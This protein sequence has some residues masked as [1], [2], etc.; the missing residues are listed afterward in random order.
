MPFGDAVRCFLLRDTTY[1]LVIK[2]FD[3][4]GVSLEIYRF[5]I[6]CFASTA[7]RLSAAEPT[8]LGWSKA[9]GRK[10]TT[11]IRDS[12]QLLRSLFC[13]FCLVLAAILILCCGDVHPHPGP[14]T[15]RQNYFNHSEST[16]DTDDDSIASS[17]AVSTCCLL[18]S[19]S[20]DVGALWQHSNSNHISRNLFPSITFLKSYNKRSCH[21][22]VFAYSKR[23][24]YCRRSLGSGNSRWH[25]LMEEP[26]LSSWLCGS[27][28]KNCSPTSDKNFDSDVLTN[29]H[30]SSSNGSDDS[31]LS[32]C[33]SDLDLALE[34]VQ[35]AS[36]FTL[37]CPKYDESSVFIAVMD[38]ISLLS[39]QTIHHVQ[40]SVR[41]LL[42]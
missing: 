42:A 10:K 3:H 24:E 35:A 15:T 14:V 11:T 40:Q 23:F 12:S 9:N 22:C 19:S 18:C 33:N 27:L 8:R 2:E 38:E 13:L 26:H 16:M 31:C 34:G 5:R 4:M 32:S 7:R 20:R 1:T 41:P 25:G 17:G 29:I 21:D 39:V 6:G 28:T 37:S 30:I 36:T